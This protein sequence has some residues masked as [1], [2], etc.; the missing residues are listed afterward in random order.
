MIGRRGRR[1]SALLAVAALAVLWTVR[2]TPLLSHA[3]DPKVL[4]HTGPRPGDLYRAAD[5]PMAGSAPEFESEGIRLL[6]WFPLNTLPGDPSSANDCWGYVAPSGREYALLGLSN[7]TAVFDV[8]VP[9]AT[10]IVDVV[11]GPE[12][13]LRDVK[14]YGDHA[15]IVSE[16][17]GGI[18]IVDLSA[19]D[20]GIV[21]LVGSI[22]DSSP[23]T[24]HNVAIDEASGF[25]YRCGGGDRGLR[26]YDLAVPAAPVLVGSWDDR[27][28]HDAQVVV[29]ESGPFA[30]RQVA[31]AC[32]G[33]NEG[34]TNT[35][36]TV[37]DVTDKGSVVVLDQTEYPDAVYSH[38]AWLSEDR[39]WLFHGD[40]LDEPHLGVPTTTRV[41]DVSDPS[42]VT[43]A[44][45]FQSTSPAG[46]HNMYVDGSRLYQANFRSGLRVLD[47]SDPTSPVETAW[48]DTWPDDDASALNG[49]WSCWPFFPSG[50]V[51][52]SDIERGLFVWRLGDPLSFRLYGRV[53]DFYAP[54][55]DTLRIAIDETE[56]ASIVPGEE[57]LFYDI[58]GGVVSVPLVEFIPG[59]YDAPIPAS[60]CGRQIRYWFRALGDDG[61]EV[62]EPEGAPDAQHRA[63]YATLLDHSF[64]DNV[65]AIA[66]WTIG[67]P[68]DTAN[69]GIWVRADP[70]GTD[71][72]PEDDHTPEPGHICFLT[73][74][75]AEGEAADASDVD[76]GLT[77][78][79]SPAFD[80]SAA[81]DPRV[82]YFR[83]FSNDEGA[84][85]SEDTMTVE[86]S[87]DDGATWTLV[88][89]VGPSSSASGGWR[90]HQFDPS[91]LVVLS[92]AMRIRFRVSDEGDDSTVEAAV[93]DFRA[94]DVRCDEVS[95]LEL[96]GLGGVDAG[97]GPPR[98]VLRINGL[99]EGDGEPIVR[100]DPETPLSFTLEE[101]PA[102]VGDGNASPAA[103][104]L[105]SRHPESTDIVPVPANLGDMCF[106]PL[107]VTTLNPQ[108]I[109]NSIGAV[110][111]LGAHDAPG[112]PPIIPDG[113][114]V[115]FLSVGSGAG[116][117]IRLTLQGFV[118]DPCTR[119]QKPV[120]ITNA[121]FLHVE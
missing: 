88:E 81:T 74:Q 20:A 52:G 94:F 38:Q 23:S 106:G 11:P 65:E 58:G 75:A 57:R 50:T 93:D 85:P 9:A 64:T 17:G 103:M 51:I 115:E 63:L 39:Q 29:L 41:F 96:C 46:G 112:P 111:R 60:E 8:T 12:S 10:T 14:T 62:F 83:W 107:V 114:S 19:V 80:L 15:Y 116:R 36:I 16:G 99:T 3:D 31:F 71:A 49:L 27:Y 121:L 7:G 32:T 47:V 28:V 92:D 109:W 87:T 30:G 43:L 6:S 35:G 120:S 54:E 89:T 34:F 24:T 70:V 66:G 1:A 72:Q 117:T 53:P 76:G 90:L 101:A 5:G 55:G 77:T 113:G 2:P 40:E 13:F 4:D 18:Q 45:T 67:S 108:F 82:S 98:T 22:D 118:L 69:E 61:V 91:K 119:G 73:G 95:P 59:V 78:L 33:F 105:W 104:Y 21:T 110:N 42:N 26:I 84:A 100:F 44:A 79:T 37:L 68:D 86:I 25:L 56:G 97:C 102:A 48:F